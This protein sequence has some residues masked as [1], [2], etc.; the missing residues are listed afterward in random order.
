VVAYLLEFPSEFAFIQSD[1]LPVRA[2]GAVLSSPG[3]LSAGVGVAVGGHRHPPVV[4]SAGRTVK[5]QWI[6]G[7]SEN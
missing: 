1:D 6:S 5:R 2:L 4:L 3:V 7:V